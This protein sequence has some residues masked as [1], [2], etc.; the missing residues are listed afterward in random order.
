MAASLAESALPHWSG[1][2]QKRRRFRPGLVDLYLVRGVAGPFLVILLAVG[3]AMMLERALR[4]VHELAA[5][6]AD[7]SY[8]L[9]LLLQLVPYYLELA[10][11]AAFM[12]ALV[13]LV[14]RL[15]DRLELEAMLASGLS[16]AR[17]A[18]PLVALGMFI[19]LAGFVAGGWLEPHGR[20]GFRALR[21]EAVNAGRLGRLE[22]RAIY[23]PAES[24]AVTFDRRSADGRIERVFLWQRLRDGREL[25]L[26]GAHGR[27]GFVPRRRAFGLDLEA[28][29]YVVD[30]PGS[31]TQPHL[32]GFDSLAFRESLRL[33]DS[34]WPRG[35]D[36]KEM[37]VP[38]L[39]RAMRAGAR[40][41]PRHVFAAELY[42]RIARAAIVP[43][44]PLLVLPLAFATKKGHRGLGIL[45]CGALLAAV[46][47]GMDFAKNLAL[48]D[49]V[50]PLAAMA[51]MAA[52]WTL[53]VLLVFV[54]GRHLPSHSPITAG[55]QR[56]SA[57]FSGL[58]PRGGAAPSVR[59]R[60]MGVY[61]AWQLGKWTLIA[62][63]GVAVLL[64]M[65]DIFERGEDFVER[66]MGAADIGYFALLRL[67]LI[68]QQALPI[69]A[70]VGAVA[71]FAR[72]GRSHEITA[73]R[74]AGISQW[75]I[76]AMALPVPLLLSVATWFLAEHVVPQSQRRFDP[77][78]A[79]SQPAG[80]TPA[81]GARW[82]RIGSDV[83]RAGQASPDGSR[84]AGIHVFRRDARGLLIERVSAASATAA[85]RGWRL[86]DVE[87]SRFEPGGVRR[88]RS[89]SRRWEVPLQPAD[90][91]AFFSSPLALTSETARRALADQAPVSQSEAL[92]TT[93]LY[94]SAA[95]PFAPVLM[96]LL[97][98]PLAF[99]APRTGMAWPALL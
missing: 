24:L 92:F 2:K 14:A 74:A 51:G 13:L 46:N 89:A 31:T 20:Y 52:A 97:A 82:F 95:E 15:D 17:I 47:H 1:D 98:L 59:G 21:I 79:A 94:R 43:L 85:T 42:S 32:L 58:A 57:L 35:W 11:P 72:L 65:V 61:L 81:P 9:P 5:R 99:V 86:S 41:I 73:I 60:T 56:V 53:L 75:R 69:A 77:W 25:V 45:V 78:W 50:A 37:T 33:E 8:L 80:R 96:L 4:L 18:A 12:V 48:G 7:I 84:L 87:S 38:E 55:L 67:P 16:L 91:A 30:Q 68:L 34:V 3:T 64:Q 71:T 62:L 88:T 28:G 10:I 76:L 36:H 19:G 44:L 83:V 90:V 70:L 40:D 54:S 22:P 26:T 23:R 63:L 27:I 66:N 29:R 49:R 6:G 39:A 93:R